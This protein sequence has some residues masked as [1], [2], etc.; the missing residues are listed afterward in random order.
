M[1]MKEQTYGGTYTGGSGLYTSANVYTVETYTPACTWRGNLY[2]HD[3]INM[4]VV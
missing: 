3:V 1:H 4:R 2:T